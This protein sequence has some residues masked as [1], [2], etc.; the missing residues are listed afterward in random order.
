[1]FRPSAPLTGSVPVPVASAAVPP[2]SVLSAVITMRSQFS[3]WT[4]L[5][6]PDFCQVNS[7]TMPSLAEASSPPSN[8][9]T[10]EM[11]N[12]LAT[13]M[14]SLPSPISKGPLTLPA[15]ASSSSSPSPS[16]MPPSALTPFSVTASWPAPETS[17]NWL[18]SPSVMVPP[19]SWTWLVVS[20][21]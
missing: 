11:S 6:A 10:P 8:T 21:D 9:V 12:A 18:A 17:A 16:E 2:R 13:S 5:T 3:H 19:L 14:E 15:W 4:V 20:T 7:S 1:M